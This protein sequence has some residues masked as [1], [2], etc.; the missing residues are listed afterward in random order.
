MKAIKSKITVNEIFN[1]LLLKKSIVLEKEPVF[2]II[3]SKI[4]L[5]GNN[6]TTFMI[7]RSIINATAL[8]SIEACARIVFPFF[9]PF[10][11][12]ANLIGYLTFWFF[13]EILVNIDN[14]KFIYR[15]NKGT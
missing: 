3:L 7:N 5:N 1:S 14:E 4:L 10:M 6:I 9:N 8:F 11:N 12:C 2:G 13:I 15:T